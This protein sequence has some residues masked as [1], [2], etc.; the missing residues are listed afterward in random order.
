MVSAH[1]LVK[2]D[3]VLGIL[4]LPSPSPDLSLPFSGSQMA[5]PKSCS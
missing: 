3:E 1:L 4:H 5:D 2:E